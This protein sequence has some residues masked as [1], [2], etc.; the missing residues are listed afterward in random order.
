VLLYIY[1]KHLI[2]LNLHQFFQNNEV[3]VIV[4]NLKKQNQP[5]FLENTTNRT[6]VDYKYVITNRLRHTN[7]WWLDKYNVYVNH[8]PR[9]TM[10]HIFVEHRKFQ[11]F[12]VKFN[13]QYL[14]SDFLAPI[15]ETINLLT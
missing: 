1:T 12:L 2:N 13:T 11:G 5:P 7:T 6:H 8:S 9:H 10:K 3:F 4:T 15:P 14:L